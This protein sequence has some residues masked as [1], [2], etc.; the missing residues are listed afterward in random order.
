MQGWK[1]IHAD[2]LTH[3]TIRDLLS[4]LEI[5]I[6]PAIVMSNKSAFTGAKAFEMMSELT[7]KSLIM[8]CP[9]SG[10]TSTKELEKMQCLES[11]I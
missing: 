3:P 10:G 5:D 11:V 6:F 8:T 2:D 7:S 1:V 4:L 9:T